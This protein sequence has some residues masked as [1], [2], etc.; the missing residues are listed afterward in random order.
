MKTI[1]TRIEDLNLTVM[2]KATLE[3]L[4]ECLYAEPGFTDVEV[5]DL[6]EH[7]KIPLNKIRGVISSLVQKEIVFVYEENVNLQKY[8]FIN[9]SSEYWY[10]HPEWKESLA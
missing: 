7:T 2:E 1:Q 6:S 10:L 8:R 9:L 4:I 5:K 3:A